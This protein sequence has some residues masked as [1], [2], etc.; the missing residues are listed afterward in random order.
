[1][2]LKLGDGHIH[3]KGSQAQTIVG[4]AF[5]HKHKKLFY[6]KSQKQCLH[7]HGLQFLI[8]LIQLVF[9]VCK[10]CAGG[11]F[12]MTK[13]LMSRAWHAFILCVY[14]QLHR[15]AHPFI[16]AHGGGGMVD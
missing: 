5:F 3:H 9:G 13:I 15:I 4:F 11:I 7:N 14:A 12:R 2:D 10:K 16:P 8:G 1:V 6:E